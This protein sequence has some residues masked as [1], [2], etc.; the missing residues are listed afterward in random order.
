M[1]LTG[2]DFK[3]RLKAFIDHE[4]PYHD[5]DSIQLHDNLPTLTIDANVAKKQEERYF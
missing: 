4:L 1:L 2:E 5:H 3:R